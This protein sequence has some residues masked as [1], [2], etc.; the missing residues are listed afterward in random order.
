MDPTLHP[1]PFPFFILSDLTLPSPLPS[2]RPH[3]LSLSLSSPPTPASFLA[4][5]AGP[6][7]PSR[8][9]L[10]SPPL[11]LRPHLVPVVRRGGHQGAARSQSA[12]FYVKNCERCMISMLVAL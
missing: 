9:G 5:T 4:M 6:S 7:F 1:R 10:P 8:F 3:T 2:A 11:R 12:F